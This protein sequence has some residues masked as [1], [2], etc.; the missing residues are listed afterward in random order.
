MPNI[1]LFF[2]STTGHT[3]H[4]ADLIKHE[5]G[6][7]LTSVNDIHNASAE[8]LESADALILGVPTWNEGELQDDWDRFL[9]T[10]DHLDLSG[11][12]VALFGLGDAAAYTNE[13]ADGLGT[14][15]QKVRQCGAEVVGAWPIEDYE[16]LRSKAVE[17][18]HFVGLVIDEDNQPDRTEQRVHDWVEMIQPVLAG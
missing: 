18:D 9:P 16:F 15:Y 4:V 12:K 1:C 5:M 14:L 11:K 13:F 17:G 2:G 8:D 10:M 6:D 3:D 7:A